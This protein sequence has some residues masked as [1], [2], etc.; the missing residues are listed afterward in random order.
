MPDISVRIHNL[1]VVVD[2]LTKL[3]GG[4]SKFMGDVVERAMR[5]DVWPRWVKQISLSD[6]TLEEL[7]LLGHPYSTRYATDSFAHPDEQ[8]HI[9]SGNLLEGSRIERK[10]TAG[11]VSVQLVNDAPEYVDLRFGTSRMRI[12]DPG[13]AALRDALPAIKARFKEE[14]KA[15]VISYI[16]K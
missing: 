3:G 11:V 14:V 1:D 10:D 6:H 9:Q 2:K 15:A 4:A 13:G 12:R 5:E 7:A 8:V 16:A